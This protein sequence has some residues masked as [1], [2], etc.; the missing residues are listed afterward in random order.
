[1]VATEAGQEMDY[2]NSRSFSIA[3]YLC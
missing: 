2:A 1:M 3:A